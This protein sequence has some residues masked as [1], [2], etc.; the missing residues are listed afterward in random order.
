M[1]AFGTQV[2]NFNEKTRE[3]KKLTIFQNYIEYMHKGKF[4]FENE[5]IT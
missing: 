2:D 5:N 4:S 3:V 1:R